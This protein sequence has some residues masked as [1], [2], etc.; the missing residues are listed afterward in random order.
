MSDTV[1]VIVA[2][3]AVL[4]VI[5]YVNYQE[6]TS[7]GF[8][9]LA[10]GVTF[11]VTQNNTLALVAGIVGASLFRAI[12][13]MRREGFE[14]KKKEGLLDKN[15]TDSIN[16]LFNNQKELMSLAEQLSPMM[17]KVEN[18]VKGLPE[19]FLEK[20]MNRLKEKK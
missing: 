1:F 6:W 20:A 17:N 5:A 15:T 7:L 8:L 14:K 2:I 19:G 18:M 3:I 11:A 12:Y 16:T 10:S 9:V 13:A 4:N